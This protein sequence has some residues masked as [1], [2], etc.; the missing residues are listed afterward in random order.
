MRYLRWT[1][2]ALAVCSL[3]ACAGTTNLRADDFGLP[4]ENARILIL[5]P[6]AD[7]GLITASGVRE[8]RAD[9][10]ETATQNLLTRFEAELGQRGLNVVHQGAEDAVDPQLLLLGETVMATALT[11]GP[12]LRGSASTARLPTKRDNFDWTI[13]RAVAPLR[14]AYDADYAMFVYSRG[15]FASAANQAMQVGIG[16]L[17]GG[18]VIPSGGQ[19][20]T[21]ISLID[22]KDGDMAWID[23]RSMGDARDPVEAAAIVRDLIDRMPTE[24]PAE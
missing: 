7:M 17:F 9:W 12:G 13:G 21:L 11:H 3:G 8:A 1:A 20:I 14:D 24:S 6:T 15:D 2:V 22:L 18:I 5:E 23:V 4:L 10:T 16:I 19:R